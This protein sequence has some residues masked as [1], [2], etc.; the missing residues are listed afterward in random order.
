M[1][2]ATLIPVSEYLSTSYSPD[3][4]Y[5][6]GEVK[7]RNMGE[8]PHAHLQNIL[9]AIFRENRKKWF[10]RALTEQRLQISPRRYRIPDV[11]ILRGSA[12]KDAIVRIAPLLCIEILSKGDSLIELQDRVDDYQSMGVHHIWVVDPWKRHGYIA[13]TRSFEQP[14]DGVLAITGTSIQVALSDLFAEL[15]E[16]WESEEPVL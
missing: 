4:D 2:S 15:D 13:T 11:C 8:Q 3:C 16:E 10:V 12:P 7:E 1:A 5:I 6:D 9:G 14:Q